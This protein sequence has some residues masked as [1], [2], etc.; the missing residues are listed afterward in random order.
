MPEHTF[1]LLAA[2]E[3]A[4]T[5]TQSA[6]DWRDRSAFCYVNERISSGTITAKPEFLMFDPTV[7]EHAEDALD[8]AEATRALDDNANYPAES[9]A[10]LKARLLR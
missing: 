2:S 7:L 8:L 5:L 9:W 6:G 4:V 1:T 10:D 3:S